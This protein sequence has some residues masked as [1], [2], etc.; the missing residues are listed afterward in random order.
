MPSIE[1]LYR[2]EVFWNLQNYWCSEGTCNHQRVLTVMSWIRRDIKPLLQHNSG[3]NLIFVPWLRSVDMVYVDGSQESNTA[4]EWTTWLMSVWNTG[5]SSNIPNEWNVLKRPKE[6]SGLCHKLTVFTLSN[7][8]GAK[9]SCTPD[10][11]TNVQKSNALQRQ[12]TNRQF[13]RKCIQ[14]SNASTMAASNRN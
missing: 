8:N 13:K 4:N 5:L 3:N 9:W 1:I 11:F 7:S 2:G 14:V 6:V 12:Y 10:N